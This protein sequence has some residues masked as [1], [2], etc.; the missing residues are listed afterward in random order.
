VGLGGASGSIQ[1]GDPV[2][3]QAGVFEKIDC[4]KG[5]KRTYSPFWEDYHTV[6]HNDN[7]SQFEQL[8][9]NGVNAG[10]VLVVTVSYPSVVQSTYPYVINTPTMQYSIHSETKGWTVTGSYADPESLFPSQ[11]AEAINERQ[12][13]PK[14]NGCSGPPFDPL[15]KTSGETTYFSGC[16]TRPTPYSCSIRTMR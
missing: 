5:G 14:Q 13:D 7:P 8:L 10:D 4:A 2:L 16:L 11:T 15:P 6:Y 9:S 3:Y 12:C 1:P